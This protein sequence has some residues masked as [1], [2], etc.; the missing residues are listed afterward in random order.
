MMNEMTFKTNQ[1]FKSI[2]YDQVGDSRC[3]VFE[4]DTTLNIYGFWRLLVNKEILI[5]SL[6][7]GHIFELPNPMDLI[8][9]MNTHLTARSLIEIKVKQ[10][11]GDMLLTLTDNYQIEIF[12]SSSAYET[13]NFTFAEKYYIGMG[14][15]KIAV[16]DKS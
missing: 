5:V 13:Y 14:G 7:Q 3:F 10:D 4:G 6:D 8:D 11:T 9:R 1:L 2:T 15:G 16:F 12:I